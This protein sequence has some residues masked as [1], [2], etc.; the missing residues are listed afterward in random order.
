MWELDGQH[1]MVAL[2]V[3]AFVAAENVKA[4]A[5]ERTLVRQMSDSLGI[6]EPGMRSLR[7]RIVREESAAPRARAAGRGSARD[8]FKV[9]EGGQG[10]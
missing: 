6:S 7:W 4:T 1:L 5:A 3:R 8:R 9:V 10:T 2:F